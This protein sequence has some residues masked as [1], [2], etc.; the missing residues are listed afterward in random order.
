MGSWGAVAVGA[1]VLAVYANQASLRLRGE[2]IA[3]DEF[4][5][6]A[7]Q[8]RQLARESQVETR[9][10]A[11]AVDTL[12]SDRDRLYSRVA[13][14]EQGLD[15][16]TGAIA[17][18]TSASPAPQAA[19]SQVSASPVGASQAGAGQTGATQGGSSPVS[20]S[21]TGSSQGTA[22]QVIASTAAPTNPAPSAL[23]AQTTPPLSSAPATT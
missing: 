22:T 10:L 19:A 1:V 3:A 2:Q 20:S 7:Q 14:L 8:I 16:V 23:A 11:S 18:Q 15:S 21:Q 12:N 13:V 17:R 4:A 5:R 6:Q 9:K